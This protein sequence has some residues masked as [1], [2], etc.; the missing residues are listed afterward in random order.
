MALARKGSVRRRGIMAYAWPLSPQ[1]GTGAAGIPRCGGGS[2][3]RWLASR[4]E[5]SGDFFGKPPVSSRRSIHHSLSRRACVHRLSRAWTEGSRPAPRDSPRPAGARWCPG[6]LSL[7]SR[8]LPRENLCWGS[9]L[10][11]LVSG[12]AGLGLLQ[13]QSSGTQDPPGATGPSGHE[14]SRPGLAGAHE[15]PVSGTLSWG[16]VALRRGEEPGMAAVCRSPCAGC[17]WGPRG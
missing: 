11:P 16:L 3:P 14:V 4:S 1:C 15:G 17:R 6:E 9:R 2:G 5:A 8:E 13:P 10:N 7:S 12:A